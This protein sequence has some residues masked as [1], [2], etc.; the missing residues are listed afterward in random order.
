[1]EDKKYHNVSE[2]GS[3]SVLRWMW[4]D[5]PTQ[6]GPLERAC[7]NHWTTYK[8]MDKVQNKPNSSVQHTP[9][10]ESFQVYQN[11]VSRSQTKVVAMSY[12]RFFLYEC[13]LGHLSESL[14]SHVAMWKQ[15][16]LKQWFTDFGFHHTLPVA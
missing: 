9:S 5:K 3:V 15:L 6:L 7:L 8:T 14:I 2:T 12:I 13:F 1:V 10:S 16:H 4:Q 11:A